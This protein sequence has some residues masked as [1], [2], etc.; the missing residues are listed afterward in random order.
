VKKL[1]IN[2]HQAISLQIHQYRSE[3]WIVLQGKAKVTLGRT[4]SMLKPNESIYVP[5]G[6][7]HR[8]ENEGDT[9]LEIIEVQIGSYL[10]E[11]D[12]KRYEDIYVRTTE[13]E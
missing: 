11:D 12:I 1:I 4:V 13:V 7:R 3:H 9:N 2:P 8:L 10:G 5:I 6:M